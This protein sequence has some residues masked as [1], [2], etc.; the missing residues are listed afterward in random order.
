M[1][2]V[3]TRESLHDKVVR[4]IALRVI[5]GSLTRLPNEADLCKE[6]QVS[7]TILRESIK[8]L[9]AKNLVRVGHGGTVVRPREDWKLLDSQLLEWVSE[10]A[11]QDFFDRLCELRQA[12]EPKAAELAARRATTKDLHAI[13]SAL[14]KMQLAGD[15]PEAYSA[16]DLHFHQCIF[17]A[18]HNELFVQVSGFTKI[19]LRMSFVFTTGKM[20]PPFAPSLRLHQRV[21][22]AI[23]DHDPVRARKH[24]QVLV[25]STT[26]EIGQLHQSQLR[27]PRRSRRMTE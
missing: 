12:L 4:N 23:R 15:I 13:H 5:L 26:I 9:A 24:M 21:F 25:E 1:G 20:G 7:R 6:L 19:F 17:T 14:E 22:R 8:V 11:G 2:H 10:N 18:S 16:A 27:R 3:I